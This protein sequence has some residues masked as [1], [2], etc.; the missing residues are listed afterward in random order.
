MER[1]VDA[2]PGDLDPL[3]RKTLAQL[4]ERDIGL[5]CHHLTQPILMSGQLALL[6]AAHL[7]GPVTAGLSPSPDKLDR[8]GRAHPKTATRRARRTARFGLFY[9]PLTKVERMSV[10]H[11]THL[12]P[13]NIQYLGVKRITLPESRQP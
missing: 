6:L 8:T 2:L 5:R 12:F 11:I 4:A 7:T 13:F 10:P 9:N 1:V 3:G